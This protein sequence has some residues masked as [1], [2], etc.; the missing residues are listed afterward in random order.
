MVECPNFS[1]HAHPVSQSP[2]DFHATQIQIA[3]KLKLV[4]DTFRF[5]KQPKIEQTAAGISRHHLAITT[6]GQ[7]QA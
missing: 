6:S 5:R 1:Q 2:G 7:I 4:S 3:K